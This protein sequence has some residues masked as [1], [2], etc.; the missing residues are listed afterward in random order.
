[1]PETVQQANGCTN[2]TKWYIYSI[3]LALGS[4]TVM[5]ILQTNR[6]TKSNKDRPL[7]L[8]TAVRVQKPGYW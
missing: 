2:T 6:A 4:N 3:T 8:N 7:K 1:M 5:D